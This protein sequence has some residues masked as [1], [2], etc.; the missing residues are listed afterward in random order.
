LFKKK[1]SSSEPSSPSSLYSKDG[2]PK[3][4]VDELQEKLL[5]LENRLK[6]CILGFQTQKKKLKQMRKKYVNL[7][8]K[9]KRDVRDFPTIFL[10]MLIE[11]LEEDIVQKIC[12]EQV[13]SENYIQ[14]D[15]KDKLKGVGVLST[16]NKIRQFGSF[17]SNTY[18]MIDGEEGEGEEKEK[19]QEK[20]IVSN[21]NNN[22]ESP[23]NW[24][25]EYDVREKCK[26]ELAFRI[27]DLESGG[28]WSSR[29]VRGGKQLEEILQK[30]E[31]K[32]AR[33]RLEKIQNGNQENNNFSDSDVSSIQSEVLNE[34]NENE[35]KIK[36]QSLENNESDDE[37]DDGERVYIVE[38]NVMEYVD[39]HTNYEK[40]M[41]QRNQLFSKKA[42]ILEI[43][44]EYKVKQKETSFS[45]PRDSSS[46]VQFS[47]EVDSSLGTFEIINV[48]FFF[49]LLFIFSTHI[50]SQGEAYFSP[51]IKERE[52]LLNEGLFIY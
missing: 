49:N 23:N 37:S 52:P 46:F 18:V 25:N 32:K 47:L 19:N 3:L 42:R 21:N 8:I 4:T 12:E 16:S 2:K 36:D 33:R 43:I 14:M 34:D 1:D 13:T 35:N 24:S 50:F 5:E 41:F 26:K 17:R 7:V 31:E 51:E 9:K 6:P 15:V 45:R 48:I 29:G 27:F 28:E 40:L 39:I 44:E 20:Q 22:N 38:A 10:T 30:E 11:D